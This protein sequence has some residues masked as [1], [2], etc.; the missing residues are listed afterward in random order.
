MRAAFLFLTLCLATGTAAAQNS[1][2][3][4]S[5][6][7]SQPAPSGTQEKKPIEQRVEQIR[8]EDGGS[9]VDELRKGGRTQSITVQPKVGDMP[10][11]QVLPAP[12]QGR[13]DGN[14]NTNGPRVWDIKKF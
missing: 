4:P 12:N 13:T 6:A 11:Y 14:D 8:V 3:P 9:R 5:G 7:P 10:A 1:T 2:P